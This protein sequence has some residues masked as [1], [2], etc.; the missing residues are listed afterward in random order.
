MDNALSVAQQTSAPSET[1]DGPW[2]GVQAGR[3]GD[4][5]SNPPLSTEID[6]WQW[7]F[8]LLTKGRP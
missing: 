6:F 7:V 3:P 4:G 1:V 5:G 8:D 2:T